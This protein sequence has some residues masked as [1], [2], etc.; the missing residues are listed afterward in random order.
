MAVMRSPSSRGSMLTRG[1]P[2]ALRDPLGNVEHAQ[3][4]DLAGVGEAQQ[5][6]VAV[7]DQQVFHEILV[8]QPRRGPSRAAPAL[9]L[10]DRQRLG[11]GVAPVRDR[12][13]HVL[14]GDEILVGEVEVGA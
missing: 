14:L 7:G 2:W 13:H 10:V 4:V 12:H 9:R 3:P 5:R 11:L 8:A 6:V 1:R